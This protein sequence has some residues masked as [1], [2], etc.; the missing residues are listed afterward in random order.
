MFMIIVLWKLKQ[1]YITKNIDTKSSGLCVE[2]HGV[3]CESFTIISIDSIEQIL[4]TS[5]FKKLHL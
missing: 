1:D 4:F 3:Q 2:E 5:A